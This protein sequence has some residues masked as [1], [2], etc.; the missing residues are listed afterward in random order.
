MPEAYAQ[1]GDI[2]NFGKNGLIIKSGQESSFSS[3]KNEKGKGRIDSP[4]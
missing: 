1:A 4:V 2:V 3:V